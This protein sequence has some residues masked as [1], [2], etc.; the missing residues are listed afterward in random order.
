MCNKETSQDKEKEDRRKN[1]VGCKKEKKKVKRVY[2]RWRQRKERKEEYL[3]LRKNFRELCKRKEAIKLE[4][5]ENKIKRA[6]TEAQIWK[7]VSR[8]K[9]TARITEGDIT[10]EEQRNHFTS[11]LERREEDRRKETEKR[12]LEDDQEE[13]LNEEEIEKQIRKMKRKKAVGADG[14]AGEAYKLW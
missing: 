5:L 14:I 4:K 3:L 7:I 6:R 11:I 9:R 1:V 8:E 13:E 10:M 2:I 12:S